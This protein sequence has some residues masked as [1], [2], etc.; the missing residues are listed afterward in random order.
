MVDVWIPATGA[1]GHLWNTPDESGTEN[2]SGA[3]SVTA[4]FTSTLSS[5]L[6]TSGDLLVSASTSATA[7]ASA[8]AAHVLAHTPLVYW[9]LGEPSGST[10]SDE[11]GNSRTGTYSGGTLGSTGLVAHDSDTAYAPGVAYRN[12]ESWMN[13][14]SAFTAEAVVRA[15][16]TSGYKAII[17]MDGNTA[18]SWNL[19]ILNGYLH[20]YDYGQSGAILTG[21][22]ALSTNVTYH[23][24]LT[25]DGTYVTLYLNGVQDGQ[26]TSSLS[27]NASSDRSLAVGASKAG[28]SSWN[29][30]FSGVIDEAVVY[31]TAL[32]QSHLKEHADLALGIFGTSGDLT[33]VAGTTSTVTV[34]RVVETSGDLAISATA[35][36][37]AT[38]SANVS[39][40]LAVAASAASAA[41]KTL[42]TSGD[43][44]VTVR[45]R[46]FEY[47][48]T[49]NADVVNDE[50]TW[51]NVSFGDAATD[52]TIVLA[53]GW[54]MGAYEPLI[55]T[56]TIGGV[57]ATIDVNYKP[58]VSGV[59]IARAVVPTGTTGTVYVKWTQ[60]AGDYVNV[61][62]YRAS[63]CSLRLHDSLAVAG[64]T[65]GTVT[66]VQDGFILAEG[67][68]SE[69]GTGQTATW[70][71]LTKNHQYNVS[72]SGSSASVDSGASGDVTVSV[73]WTGTPNSRTLVAVAYEAVNV[74]AVKSTSG[75]LG[76][77]AARTGAAARAVSVSGN[78][79]A[80]AAASGT[81]AR[82]LS[83]SGDLA[84]SGTATGQDSRTATTSGALAV[85]G[86]ASGTAQR[87][88][89]VAGDRSVT[90]SSTAEASRAT[91]TSG[92]VAVTA[93]RAGTLGRSAPTSGN[94][95]VTGSLAGSTLREA[96]A[97][98]S[99]A[100]GAS[101]GASTQRTAES[102]GDLAVTV[103]LESD[104]TLASEPLSTSGD[105]AVTASFTS[106]VSRSAGTSG[107]LSV[108]AGTSSSVSR[109]LETSG[110]LSVAGTATA[111]DERTA[112]TSGSLAV[113]A[114]ASGT[115][116]RE[117]P[118]SGDMSV[119]AELA[120]ET[121]RALGAAGDLS[122]TAP[123]TG[124]T[125]R[126]TSTSGDMSVTGSVTAGAQSALGSAGD[127]AVSVSLAS[128]AEV[129]G[130]PLSTSGD[131]AVSVSLSG[132]AQGVLS[133]SG[134]A[135]TSWS[136][137]ASARRI[138]LVSG[139][140]AVS[141]STGAG[142]STRATWV[143]TEAGWRHVTSLLVRSADD[144]WVPVR[145]LHVG[146]GTGYDK[147][148]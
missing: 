126:S 7:A 77:T 30:T 115:T 131:L 54:Y 107:D 146:T 64:T 35:S 60:Y 79:A 45:R 9:R 106:T 101:T 37:T 114:P 87:V 42:S 11:S 119:T 118:T 18:R 112:S 104:V 85:S 12:H 39:G 148:L 113:S 47:L 81:A 103:S 137:D 2:T 136:S 123:R 75:T 111:G 76:V 122:V 19:Y 88:T 4:S 41:S 135:E 55:D 100:V 59:A 3:T 36:G 13:L 70:T 73:A 83:T 29:F 33:V 52:R 125:T 144:E 124:T 57:T 21:S 49:V 1:Q 22:T 94:L 84:V 96:H 26:T 34:A 8:Y 53:I 43:L 95:S 133:T 63:G 91:G 143:Y 110:D 138:V 129:I 50:V 6:N 98:G 92:D 145:E 121:A 40:N 147:V 82:A 51:N 97:S 130:E 69:G 78:L 27:T 65:S 28:S 127:L 66:A 89:G 134:D 99:L 25:Y 116:L 108:S 120:A 10:A 139:D 141:W 62:V 74:S 32:S 48:T 24:A 15:T 61:G 90:A 71:G 142:T 17:N 31:G 72:G 58:N 109:T 23:V 44:A 16:S 68:A 38:R 93:S 128:T 80:A 46:R 5:V 102:A 56:V 14:G 140:A 117:A 86:T 105:L 20:V 67:Q 132:A